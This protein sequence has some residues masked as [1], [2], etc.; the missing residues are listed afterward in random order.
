ME[1]FYKK[2]SVKII[3][4][5]LAVL[6]FLPIL[7]C[8][9]QPEKQT[10]TWF[11]ADGT[12]IDSL[13]V[14]AN[15]DPTERIL[16]EDTDQ[17]HYTDWSVSV[18]G[19]NTVCTAVRTSKTIVIWKDAD[20][21]V[22]EETFIT[23]GNSVIPK[24]LP[25]SNDKWE[26]TDWAKE[27][28]NDKIEYTALRTPNISYFYGNV[29]QIVTK[30]STGEPLSVGSGFI[31]NDEGWFITN[32]HVMDGGYSATAYFDIKDNESGTRH[33]TL[34]IIGGVYNDEKK[35]IFIGKLAGYEKIR[36]YYKNIPFTEEY[37]EGDT[38]YS[39]GY[40]NAAVTLE[41]NKGS[42]LE[43]YANIR[44]KINGVYYLLSDC[45]IAPGSSGGILLS[46]NFEVIGITSMGL[47][48]DDAKTE[49]ISGGSV[50][51]F[52]FKEQIKN[53]RESELRSLVEIYGDLSKIERGE[54]VL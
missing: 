33:T 7:G 48:A 18:S 27:T 40:P 31:L 45:Y 28:N 34:D 39:I 41:L 10:V 50:P 23:E 12:K 13:S 8:G 21:T 38:C 2:R 42:V 22:L 43:E 26:Y 44:D 53:L 4:T 6:L 52:A 54:T 16:P 35:D 1:R 14:D 36:D 3:S 49:L 9:K 46:E 24:D 25:E 37:A 51:T 17:W 20:G 15:Y 19:K 47:Y 5:L 29:F 11:D 32:N 30:D